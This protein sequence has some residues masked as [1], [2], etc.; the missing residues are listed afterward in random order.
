MNAPGGR[1]GAGRRTTLIGLLVVAVVLAAVVYPLR[2]YV[3]EPRRQRLLGE[4]E[5]PGRRLA[6]CSQFAFSTAAGAAVRILPGRPALELSDLPS[7]AVTLILGGFRGPYVVYLWIKVEEEKHEKVHFDLIDRYTK[8]ASLQSDYPEMWVYHGWNLAWN[9]SV[10]W[11]SLERKYQWIRRGAEFMREGHRQNP[12]SARIAAEIGRLYAEKLGRSQEA[13][14]FR[15][16]VR[17]EEGR[18]P[19]LIAY[20]WYDLARKLN[21]RYDS[22]GRGLSEPVTYSQA[23]H[24]LSYYATALTQRVYDAF[25]ASM[26]ARAAGRDEEA[27]RAFER[28]MERLDRA[29]DAWAWARRE[30]HDQAIRFEREATVAGLIEVYRRFHDQAD[31][32]HKGLVALRETLTYENLPQ[33]FERME[34]PTIR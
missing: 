12:H 10:Q 7:K 19:F 22:L 6:L 21:D 24:N 26:D 29:I 34:R 33:T 14:Y 28:G 20:E 25:K 16:R 3:V 18:S 9:V 5:P 30:W 1:N 4:H 13:F 32:S 27:R 11:Q 31:D 2:R 23:C 8:I 17:E 15:D